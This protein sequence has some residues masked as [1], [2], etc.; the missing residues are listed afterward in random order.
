MIETH[1]FLQN[2]SRKYIMYSR[3]SCQYALTLNT[4][5]LKIHYY[6]GT[7]TILFS[8]NVLYTKN[9]MKRDMLVLH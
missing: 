7:T 8:F 2:I 9:T 5:D 3:K 4:G 1:L 6:I